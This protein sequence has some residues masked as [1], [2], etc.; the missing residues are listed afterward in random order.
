MRQPCPQIQLAAVN[1]QKA[2]LVKAAS[3]QWILGAS[4]VESDEVAGV[5]IADRYMKNWDL[6]QG[7]GKSI[8]RVKSCTVGVW[9]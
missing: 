6:W 9:Y 8:G 5:P 4:H 3:N 7:L 1:F 2:R